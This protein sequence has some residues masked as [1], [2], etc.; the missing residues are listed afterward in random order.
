MAHILRIG[1]NLFS[2]YFT[3]M[4]AKIC[5]QHNQHKLRHQKTSTVSQCQVTVFN[6]VLVFPLLEFPLKE[7]KIVVCVYKTYMT[8][9]A[10]NLIGQ[11]TVGKTKNS[12]DKHWS[13]M[14]RLVRQ[15]VA[16]WHSLLI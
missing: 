5:V 12:E 4:Y 13:L 16:K 3:A 9:S 14:M 11:L 7:C 6:E 1:S 15:P 10:K 8:K 2:L